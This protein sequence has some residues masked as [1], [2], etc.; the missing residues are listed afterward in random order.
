VK[1]SKAIVAG[2]RIGGLVTAAVVAKHFEEVVLIDRDDIPGN[3]S[4]RNG[5]PQGSYLHG[6][7]P[8]GMNVLAELF[9][10][11]EDDLKQAGGLTPSRVNSM[12]SCPK[13]SL[14]APW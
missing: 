2:G 14:T 3:A 1:P 9:P 11:F 13:A 4:V 12:L 5:V 7:L 6:V 8:G 10:G